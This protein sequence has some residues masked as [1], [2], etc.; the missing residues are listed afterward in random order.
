MLMLNFLLGCEPSLTL[1]LD[2]V[3][4]IVEEFS[5]TDLGGVSSKAVDEIIVRSFQSWEKPMCDFLTKIETSLN[6]IV[7]KAADVSISDWE[8][9]IL[10]KNSLVTARKVLE[11]QFTEL[12]YVANKE[13]ALEKYGPVA[14]NKDGIKMFEYESAKAIKETRRNIRADIWFD[15]QETLTG[16]K[17]S[18]S[19]RRKQVKN[20]QTLID[21]CKSIGA[22]K[23]Q[24]EIDAI[25]QI[26][27]YYHYA[28]T[29]FVDRL[30]QHIQVEL[31]ELFRGHSFED[32]VK[33]ELGLDGS[34]SG[35]I[36]VSSCSYLAITNRHIRRSR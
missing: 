23:F 24:A 25:I 5:A 33:K 31:F 3:R 8:K 7:T 14:K 22:D 35:K 16:M 13:L 32:E 34:E 36:L 17:T 19:Q 1:S 4:I 20:D 12:R 10:F 28:A 9:T 29:R 26:K 11:N 15:E 21:T 2:Q 6:E 27:G 30:C 18:L